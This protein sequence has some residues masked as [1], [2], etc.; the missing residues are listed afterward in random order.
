MIAIRASQEQ[1]LIPDLIGINMALVL[2]ALLS[3]VGCV[4]IGFVYGWKLTL[5]T[6]FVALPIIMGTY[7]SHFFLPQD[8]SLTILQEVPIFDS[9]SRFSLKL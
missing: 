7:L 1:M 8:A 4:V 9:V 5:L 3:I 2:T 6:V